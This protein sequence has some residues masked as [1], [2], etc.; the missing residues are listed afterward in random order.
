LGTTTPTRGYATGEVESK[1]SRC[2]VLLLFPR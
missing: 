1:T 2:D